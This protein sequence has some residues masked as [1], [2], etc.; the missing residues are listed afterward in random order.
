MICSMKQGLSH[1]EVHALHAAL[2]S[3]EMQPLLGVNSCCF[4]RALYHLKS[5]QTDGLYDKT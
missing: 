5:F 1:K 2:V 3:T 4:V